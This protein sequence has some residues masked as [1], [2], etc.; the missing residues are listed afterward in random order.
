[1][2]DHFLVA[3]RGEKEELAGLFGSPEFV[4]EALSRVIVGDFEMWKV[5]D[6]GQRYG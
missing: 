6:P 3:A 4:S 1:M 5:L 2:R